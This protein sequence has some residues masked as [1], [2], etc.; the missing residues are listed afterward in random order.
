MAQSWWTCTLRKDRYKFRH[1]FSKLFKILIVF[2]Y[3]LKFADSPVPFIQ[4]PGNMAVNLPA[5][6]NRAY[7]TFSQPKSNM[8]WFRYE[9]HYS[10]GS[11]PRISYF[12]S[13]KNF[14]FVL[15]FFFLFTMK[16]R[17]FGSFMGETIGWGAAGWFER[18]H[19]PG[20]IARFG[21]HSRL[22]LYHRNLWYLMSLKK[23]I[24]WSSIS[25]CFFS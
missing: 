7:V 11:S 5:Q 19:F 6:Q 25:L 16:L 24:S 8:D 13:R 14:W 4:C 21:S 15:L 18:H 23:K 1:V 17:G 20:P 12:M 2:F 3:V 9:L 22:Q 10:D